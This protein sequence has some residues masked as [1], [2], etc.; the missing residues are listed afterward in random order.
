MKVRIEC[1][2]AEFDSMCRGGACIGNIV[3]KTCPANLTCSECFKEYAEVIITDG[4]AEDGGSG[5]AE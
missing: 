4:G 5:S 1:T 2:Q 3:S